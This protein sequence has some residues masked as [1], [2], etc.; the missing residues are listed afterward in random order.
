MVDVVPLRTRFSDIT[1]REPEAS[2]PG[3]S[4]KKASTDKGKQIL[5]EEEH[6][7]TRNI[8]THKSNVPFVTY[9][10]LR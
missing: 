9:A 6:V 8:K 2:V 7:Y 4:I 3:P 10:F 5:G 1:I